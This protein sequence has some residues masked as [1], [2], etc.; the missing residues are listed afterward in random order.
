MRHI[1]TGPLAEALV[2]TPSVVVGY[3]T[4][5][6]SEKLYNDQP[7]SRLTCLAPHAGGETVTVTVP[8]S[9]PGLT[10][11]EVAQRV[12]T[13]D[14]VRAHFTGL[15]A[16]VRG[17]EFNRVTYTATADKAEVVTAPPAPGGKT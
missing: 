7:Y 14:F 16:E 4:G 2:G 11:A 12:A 9:V 8:G 10:P 17:G 1:F 6:Q 5:L 3:E 15:T 13:L